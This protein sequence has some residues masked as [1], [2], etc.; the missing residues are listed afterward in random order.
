MHI[1]T[2]GLLA[3]FLCAPLAYPED[4]ASRLQQLEERN[5]K[6]EERVRVLERSQLDEEVERYLEQQEAAQGQEGLLPGAQALRITGEIRIRQ[7]FQDR[8]YR[9]ADADGDESFEFAHMRTRLRFDVDVL[10]NLGVVIELQDIRIFGDELS[11]IGDSEGVDLKRGM[12]VFR[13]VGGR[14]ITV[15]AGRFVMYYGDHRLIGH[16]EWF[17]Q[18]RTYDGLRVRIAPEG[19]FLDFFAVRVRETVGPGGLIVPDDDQWFAGAYGGTERLEA[20]ALVF[21]DGRAA[22][23]ET[24]VDD[25]LFVT[26]GL[27]AH[28]KRD[29]WDYTAEV[30]FQTGD[31]HGDDL[32]GFAFAVVGG[33]TFEDLAWRPRVGVEVDFATGDEDPTDGETEQFQTLFPTNHLHY[34]YMDLVGWSNVL[35]LRVNVTLRPRERWTITI[36]FHHLR[37]PEETGAWVNAGGAVIRPGLAGSDGHLGDEVDLTVVWKP[38]DPLSFLLGYSIFVPGGFVE[39][40]GGDPTAHFLYVQTRVK[41]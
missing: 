32:S 30:A 24:G 8:V 4:P 40:T 10:D 19:G 37:R 7:E 16:L 23:G 15:E 9:P 31:V 41:F 25:T 11:T 6:L 33:Y 35:D 14:P 12:I 18:G 28:G 2:V 29:G 36:D 34:G 17:D 21:G 27:R 22:A 26:L 1:A 39:E 38:N 13:Q 5:R 3:L 20:Y